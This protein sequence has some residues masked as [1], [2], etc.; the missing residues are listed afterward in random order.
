MDA[1]SVPQ[2]PVASLPFDAAILAGQLRESSIAMYRR[3]FA[4]YLSF[5]T[6]TVLDPLQPATF[7]RWRAALA[8]ETTLSPHT[9]NRMLSAVKR[10][11]REAAE[12]GYLSHELA[13]AFQDRRGVQVRALKERLK[14]HGR[15][16][17]NPE[18][19]R[20]LCN[21]PD[22]A[23]LKGLRDAA[24]LH[25]LASSGIR[26]SEAAT[27]TLDQIQQ[28]TQHGKT[29]YVLLVRGKT[30]EAAR[31]APLSVEAYSAILAW[32]ERCP[33]ASLWLFPA[34]DGRGQ[35]WQARPMTTV[36]V[37]QTVQSY[38]RQCQLSHL[39][40]HD[41]RRFVGTQLARQD[42][43]KAQMALGHKRIDT[44]AQHY[45]LNELEVGL[46]EAMY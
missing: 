41:F 42:I 27:L 4:A 37:W 39:K 38:A 23:T 40:P 34:Q 24:L 9:I 21:A 16:R 19:M 22:R 33:I 18:D 45:D 30:D 32:R 20:R 12:Q 11:M 15:T 8:K 10:L 3:D 7:S 13:E 14:P 1:L 35:R 28:K 6:T 25:T 31:E 44:T 26:V 17:I 5:A 36:S 46:T 2:A 29:G 43:R